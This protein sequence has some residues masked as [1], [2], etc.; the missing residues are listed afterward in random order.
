MKQIFKLPDVGEGIAEAEIVEYLVEVGDKV[1]ADQTVVRVETDKAV[2]EL[3]SPFSGTVS[4]IPHKPGD[5]VKVG[6]A[7]LI[8]DTEEVAASEEEKKKPEREKK[9]QAAPAQEK[10]KPEPADRE[11][12]REEPPR[13]EPG[14]A[15]ESGKVLATPHTRKLARELKVDITTV[16]GS[17][18]QGRITDDDVRRAGEEAAR[19]KEAPAAASAKVPST[20]G[21]DFE[22]YGPTRRVPL[23]GVRKRVAE[24]MARS[25]STI[26]HVTHFDEADVT[27]LLE[28][29]EREHALAESRGIKLTILSFLAKAAAA[30]L[31]E[32]PV[33]NSSLDE[34]TGEIVYKQYIHIGIATDTEAGLMVPVI[35]DV[36]RKSILQIASEL[37]ELAKK[38][39][40]RSIDLEDLRGGSFSI[41]NVGAI[42]G[43]GA[44]PIIQHPQAAILLSVR[45]NKKPVVRDDQ[46]VIR[47]MMPL[48]L[49]FDHR[50]LDGA[51]AA[52]FMNH[53]IDLL[54]DPMRMLIDVA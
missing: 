17:G 24:V 54:E 30:S 27:K 28:V 19:P 6:D 50:I 49:S 7:L 46:V 25:A 36:D 9:L 44:T 34:E 37:Q 31:Q 47:T 35:R 2:V 42:G 20:T 53:L 41:T 3:P 18:P 4:E 45:A 48:A 26:P 23:K 51:E 14:K 10:R 22:K 13:P 43:T 33:L 21:F 52:R 8:V 16:K 1:K 39:R 32:F 29:T 38:A 12:K 5:T 15:T 11:E 40:E